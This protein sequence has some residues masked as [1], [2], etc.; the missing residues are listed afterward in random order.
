MKLVVA[1]D[2]SDQDFAALN[3]AVQLYRPTEVTLVHAVDMGLYF[4]QS[5]SV[6]HETDRGGQLLDRAAAKVPAEVKTVRKVNETGSPAQLILDNADNVTADLVVI[7]TRGRGSLAKTWFGSV[8]DRVLLHATRSTM[9]VQGEARKVQ[10]VLV[11]VEGPEDADRIARWLTTHPFKD[12]VELCVVHAVAPIEVK[13]TP[14]DTAG[15]K[16]LPEGAERIAEELVK[17]TAGKLSGSSYK[18]STKV[19][20][21]R[22]AAVIQEQAKDKDLVVVSSHGRR[23]LSRFMMG[24][25]SH[26][27]VHEVECPVLVVR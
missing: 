4:E 12:S 19:A 8:S 11:A 10:R 26:S 5:A 9:I 25:V 13:K 15:T 2:W 23:G 17:A 22:P 3:L 24:S 14:N 7:G 21:G 1:V 6:G 20:V 16:A 18:V 27:V